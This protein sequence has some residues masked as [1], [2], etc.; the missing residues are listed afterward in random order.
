MDFTGGSGMN[1]QD[2]ELAYELIKKAFPEYSITREA[3][4]PVLKMVRDKEI[5]FGS[6]LWSGSVS[7]HPRENYNNKT[8][9]KFAKWINSI[10]KEEVMNDDISEM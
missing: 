4:E 9:E 3:C 2:E 10:K 6:P 8:L 5:M 1:T 7:I